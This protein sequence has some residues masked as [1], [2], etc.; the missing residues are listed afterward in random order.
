MAGY[1]VGSL[2]PVGR[3]PSADKRGM[4]ILVGALLLIGEPFEA[5]REEDTTLHSQ[6]IHRQFTRHY[7]K[8]L[9]TQEINLEEKS[10][11]MHIN[12]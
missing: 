8:R 11:L 12:P 10:A 1:A 2:V 7:C 6:F 3:F 9:Q 5:D 4:R